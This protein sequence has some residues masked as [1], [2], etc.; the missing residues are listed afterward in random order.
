MTPHSAPSPSPS[1]WSPGLWRGS[2][3]AR[4]GGAISLPGVAR[5][6]AGL[7]P[8]ADGRDDLLLGVPQ[9]VLDHAHPTLPGVLLLERGPA[10]GERAAFLVEPQAAFVAA[11][12]LGPAP[13]QFEEM[14]DGRLGLLH[15]QGAGALGVLGDDGHRRELG[16]AE[17]AGGDRR[18][19]RPPRERPAEG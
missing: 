12:D 13:R 4:A 3:P 7:F 17:D 11:A 10:P 14:V 8:G 18:R 15:R 2:F 9:G 16:V 5:L 19:P 6:V 1:R